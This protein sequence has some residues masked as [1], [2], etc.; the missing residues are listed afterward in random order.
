NV[1][2][3]DAADGGLEELAKLDDVVGAFR[4]NLEVEDIDVGELLEEVC[5]A[6][7]HRL[8]GHG[9]DVAKPAHSGSVGDEAKEIALRCV[10]VREIRISLDLEAGLGNSGRVSKRQIPLVG[11]RLRR[12]YRDFSRAAVRVVVESVLAFGHG[13]HEQ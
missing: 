2:E 5:L 10:C 9:P 1:L 12:N 11:Q 6:L 13:E 8:A 3:V 4:T 7:H